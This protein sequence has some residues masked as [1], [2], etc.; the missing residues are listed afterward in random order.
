MTTSAVTIRADA[1]PAEAARLMYRHGAPSLLVVD[2][3]GR[4]VGIV[5]RGDILGVFMRSD[6]AIL[7]EIVQGVIV[8]DFVLDPHAFTVV[9]RD[10]VVTLAGHPETG[11]VGHHLVEA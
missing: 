3:A 6:A 4:L 7:R 5:S 8:K 9:V 1:A 2:A 10:G 11:A